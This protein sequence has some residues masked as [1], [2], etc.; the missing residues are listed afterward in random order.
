MTEETAKKFGIIT[1]MG[2]FCFKTLPF[3]GAVNA[4]FIFSNFLYGLLPQEGIFTYMDDILI[5]NEDM[6]AHIRKIEE[7]C[8]RLNENGLQVNILKTQLIQKEVKFLGYIISEN[9]ISPSMDKIKAISNWQIPQTTTEVRSVISFLNYFR[10]FVPLVSSLTS[11]LRGLIKDNATKNLPVRHTKESTVAFQSL[12]ETLI[13]LPCLYIYQPNQPTYIFTDSSDLAIGG[14]IC[15]ANDIKGVQVLVSISFASFKL[16]P[17]QTRYSAMEN[18]LSAIITI[19]KK[20]NYLCSGDV[21]VHSD[22]QSLSILQDKTTVPPLRV[23]RFL[24]V[25]GAYAPKIFYLEGKKNFMADILSRYETNNIAN[26][27][28]ETEL[29]RDSQFA[30]IQTKVELQAIS[31][32]KLNERQLEEIQARLSEDTEADADPDSLPIQSFRMFNEELC[33]YLDTRLVKVVSREEFLKKAT[34]VHEKL[35]SSIRV[36]DYLTTLQVWH[37]DHVL[38]TTE[39]IR[40]CNHCQL[41]STF[42]AVT[43]QLFPLDLSLLFNVGELIL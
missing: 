40:Q 5:F 24:D 21:E 20:Y 1:H 30:T 27:I 32:E 28:D 9:K 2:N 3:F 41:H 4:P 15:Q 29:L 39:I 23:A 38:L 18:E 26:G 42:R 35:H 14:F 25:L 34:E 43:R 17:T 13:E 33:V 31:L 8:E 7:V 12:K 10:Q 37:P 6:E 11:P 36:T 19:L 22:H 16:T